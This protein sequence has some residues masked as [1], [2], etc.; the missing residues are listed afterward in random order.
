[1]RGSVMAGKYRP[2]RQRRSVAQRDHLF[3]DGAGRTQLRAAFEDEPAANRAINRIRSLT[4]RRYS[5]YPCS[6][7][8]CNAW[9]I[10]PCRRR[11]VD[12]ARPA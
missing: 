2:S 12:L 1:M 4:G 8:G 3:V 10:R 11:H 6:W 7:R 9:H 5:H